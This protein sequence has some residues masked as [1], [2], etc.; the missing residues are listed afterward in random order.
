VTDETR[1]G[2][3]PETPAEQPSDAAETSAAQ[4]TATTDPETGPK[5]LEAEQPVE[6]EARPG[7]A[8]AEK[9]APREAAP[10]EAS[11]EAA[12][13]D[14]EE[15][16]PAKAAPAKAAPAKPAATVP[17]GPD[18]HPLVAE[19]MKKA[20]LVWVELL[21]MPA[22]PAWCVWIDGALY[23]VSGPGEQPVPGLADASRASVVVRSADTLAR[24]V[25]WP[26]AV[27][28]VQPGT[29]E[30]DAAVPTLL[31][32]RLN[33]AGAEDAAKRWAAECVVNR[34]EPAADPDQAGASL[35]ATG[36]RAAPPAT[37]AATRTT[38]PYT[39]GRGRGRRRQH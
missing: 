5:T 8:P 15:K 29:E 3:E 12:G 7:K 33:L 14:G 9:A 17:P 11:R 10:R 26:A 23:I 31:G 39:V 28:R 25:R 38:V 4:P 21:G 1:A 2:A 32:K 16:A 13:K 24:I 19:V 34:L 22:A 20:P 36:H 30:W 35:P 37:P 18:A 6:D 27:R